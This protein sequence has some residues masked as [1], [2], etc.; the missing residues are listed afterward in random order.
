MIWL[1]LYLY[2][3]GALMMVMAIAANGES[4]SDWRTMILIVFWPTVIPLTLI[5]GLLGARGP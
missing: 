2:V 5:T 1:A 4:I 3:A